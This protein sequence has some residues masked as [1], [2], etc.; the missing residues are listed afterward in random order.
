MPYRAFV[1]STFEDLKDHR[2]HVIAALRA[3]GIHVDPMEEW[4]ASTGEPKQFSQDR[5]NGCDLCVLLV[6]FR[7][8]H[9][10]ENETLSIT[11]LEYRA[12][13]TQGSCVLAFLLKDNA[14]WLREFDEREKDPK[15]ES[16]RADLMKQRGVGWFNH[17]PSSINIAPALTRWVADR[18]LQD[19]EHKSVAEPKQDKPNYSQTHRQ[20]LLGRVQRE[21]IERGLDQ[22]LY[23]LGKIEL[24]LEKTPSAVAEGLG[25]GAFPTPDPT[26]VPARTPIFDV[27]ENC[28]KALLILAKPGCGKTT[29][30]L[31]LTKC[32]LDCA[33]QDDHGLVPVVFHLSSWAKRRLPLAQWLVAY[34]DDKKYGRVPKELA[35]GWVN[36]GEI[37]PLLDGLDTVSIK[38]RGQCVEAI[39]AFCSDHPGLPIAVCSRKDDY[40]TVG[41]KLQLASAIEI[42]PLTQDQ[43]SD[44]LQG[45]GEMRAVRAALEAD[46]SLCKLLDTPL[47]LW[48]AQKAYNDSSF[49]VSGGSNLDQ[50]RTQLFAKFV[51]EML[52]ERSE[53][54]R[55][56]LSV[57]ARA[58]GIKGRPAVASPYPSKQARSWLSAVAC[59]LIR[60]REEVFYLE[61]LRPE[62]L[63]TPAQ[64]WLSIGG[65][66]LGAGLLLGLFFG[67]IDGL[68]IG[69]RRGPLA[70]LSQGAGVALVFGLIYAVFALLI[71]L[72]ERVSI[73][74]MDISRR[75]R[76]TVVGLGAWAIFG[77]IVVVIEWGNVGLIK[78]LIA[79]GFEGLIVGLL[80]G[81]ASLLRPQPRETRRVP[82]EGTHHSAIAAIATVVIIEVIGAP[83]AWMFTARPHAGM[84]DC[85]FPGMFL[86]FVGGLAFGG[87][88]CIGHVVLRLVLWVN[89]EAPLR[90]VKFLDYAVDRQL[91]KKNGGGYTFLDPV[92]TKYFASL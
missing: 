88:L 9:V 77:L 56:W 24:V 13:V 7:R 3:A 14:L 86:G 68:I 36:N 49:E 80:V 39:N 30:L 28:G 8:G 59:A 52:K 65:T 35:E 41:K 62:W 32:L 5:V 33:T 79:G 92:L 20:A 71:W 44:Y 63:A 11:Q 27:F 60:R 42:R 85:L 54:A 25:L 84:F 40:E 72:M 57:V 29:L 48:V 58:S 66:L 82:N 67:L 50:R 2:A 31:E 70:G 75:R 91:M 46:A 74:L 61:D 18:S 23:K 51:D 37:I 17:E 73:G 81:V 4:T 26:P 21:L 43:V 76:A 22:S 1:S 64:T 78:G 34:L 45:V 47:M 83:V 87:L 16:W 10:P 89:G 69:L 15:L 12:A 38:H 55:S 19:P 6:A 53:Q 90:Y